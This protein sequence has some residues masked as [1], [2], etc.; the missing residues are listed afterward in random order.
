MA[1]RKATSTSLLSTTT[2]KMLMSLWGVSWIHSLFCDTRC[3]TLIY[4]VSSWSPNSPV[5]YL[6][7]CSCKHANLSNSANRAICYP[8]SLIKWFRDDNLIGCQTCQTCQPP[9]SVFHCCNRLSVGLMSKAK[10]KIQ[11]SSRW[12]INSTF[13]DFIMSDIKKLQARQEAAAEAWKALTTT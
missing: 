13:R 11:R 2:W 4:H 8:V 7:I 5:L 3:I 9:L 12:A 6:N 1:R 10:N